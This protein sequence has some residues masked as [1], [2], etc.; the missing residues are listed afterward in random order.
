MRIGE[1]L[2]ARGAATADQV[3]AALATKGSSRLGSR[4]IELG[5]TDIDTVSRALAEQKCV[6]AARL[7]HFK[8]PDTNAVH[9]IDPTLAA[10]YQAV[11]L[12]FMRSTGDPARSGTEAGP[13]QLAVA[14]RDPDDRATA[15]AIEQATGYPVTGC[16][17]PEFLLRKALQQFYDIQPVLELATVNPISRAQPNHGA[18]S[19]N[20][21][22]PPPAAS[23]PAGTCAGHPG[24]P[25][26]FSCPGCR[27]E[28]CFDCSDHRW[29]NNGFVDRCRSCQ[30][31]LEPVSGAGKRKPWKASVPLTA[32][33]I[34]DAVSGV[35][36]YMAQLP[37]VI[38][39]PFTSSGLLLLL[40]LAVITTPLLMLVIPSITLFAIMG[41]HSLIALASMLLGLAIKVGL[42]FTVFFGIVSNTAT[43]QDT[44]RFRDCWRLGGS[45]FSSIWRFLAA[46]LPLIVAV[47][48][49]AASLDRPILPMLSD[50]QLYTSVALL[51]IGAPLFAVVG[52]IAL[53]PLLILVAAMSNSAFE[54]LDPRLWLRTLHEIGPSYI[55]G[56]LA[57]YGIFAVEITVLYPR[58]EQL[59]LATDSALFGAFLT[60]FLGYI[61]IAIRMR[62][63]GAL[64]R[65]YF[66]RALVA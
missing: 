66:E 8:H 43:G 65:R 6:P 55:V 64:L 30:H 23:A 3:E 18:P 25:A 9:A 7:D 56:A 59:A 21:G 57:F 54:V 12:G 13:R 47:I 16:A 32:A 58:L 11:P 36:A 41:Y 24:Q 63:L 44:I 17:A 4:L 28:W 31:T 34:G 35:G 14:M 42:E 40:A 62:L 49:L 5:Y 61:P 27:A 46:Y 60:T 22:A 33:V 37:R 2:I 10:L 39:F 38:L 19:P 48:W 29:A 15:S 50:K 51:H 26:A 20:R 52:A 53:L 1:I 45:L